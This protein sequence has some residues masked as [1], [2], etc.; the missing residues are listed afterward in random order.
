MKRVAERNKADRRLLLGAAAVLLLAMVL[1]LAVN[2]NLTVYSDDYWYGTFFQEGWRG[3]WENTKEHY[4][5]TNGRVLIHILIPLLLL[6]DTKIFVL[7]SPVLTALILLLGLRV[8]NRSMGPAALLL[9]SGLG[10]LSVLGSEI[11]YLRMALYW[12]SAYFNY[13]FPLLFPL[14]VL[15]GMMRVEK[16][17]GSP[18]GLAALG[19][20]AL[21]AG[22]STEQCGLV[23]LVVLWGYW[24]LRLRKNGRRR[25]G[26]ALFPVLASVGYLTVLT[27]PGSHAR[28]ERGIDGGIFSVLDPQVFLTRFFDVMGYLCG[29]GFWNVLF[30]VFCLLLGLLALRDRRLPRHLLSAFPAAALVVLLAVAGWQKPL[31]ALTVLYTLYS[32]VT[33]LFRPRYQVTGLLLLGAGASVMMLVI[34]TLYYARTFFPCLLLFLTVVWSLLFRVLDKGSFRVSALVCALLAVVFVVRYVPIY[35]GYAANRAVIDENLQAI[36]ASRTSGELSL[37]IDLDPDYRFTMFFEGTYFLENFLQ[38]YGLPQD[39][40]LT[41]TSQIWDI[42]Q[43]QVGD[44]RSTFPA[45]EKDGELLLPLE[46][47]FQASGNLCQFYW[48][49]HT[50][51]ITYEGE[52]YTL[53][54][55]GR[56]I[57]HLPEGGE[58]VVDTNCAPRM[59]FSYT[60]TLLYLPA[61][62]LSRCFGISFAYDQENDCYVF[63]G[64]AAQGGAE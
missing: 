52:A 1:E 22:A 40:P 15:W 35:T 32:A 55:D 13:V 57:R 29:Y 33:L 39:I 54:E 44:Q 25:W 51:A 42:S 11:Q 27:A 37:S 10:L 19:V 41:F 18:L 53:Y 26:L 34:T 7:V 64:T 24:L 60:Y 43:V 5:T 4:Q 36:E 49:D 14:L 59:P 9:A 8:Q 17:K 31:A 6:A 21:V 12:L 62:D 3:F 46:F 56:L 20:C 48:T 30:A 2:R 50:F 38:Y 23:A 58:E 28:M 47:V 63:Q 16:G 45:L 61:E